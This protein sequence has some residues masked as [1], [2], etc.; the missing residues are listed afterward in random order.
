MD[1]VRYKKTGKNKYKITLSN[2]VELTIYEDVILK[3]ELL[4]KKKIND[5]DLNKIKELNSYY[6][7]YYFAVNSLNSKFKSISDMKKILKDKEYSDTI[8]DDVTNKLIEQGYLNDNSYARSFI[9]NQIITTN[10]G[11]YKIISELNKHNIKSSIVNEEIDVF[12]EDIQ[13]EKMDKVINKSLKSNK[14]RGGVVLKKKII[15]DLINLG[16]SI[17]IIDKVINKYKFN[18]DKD[19]VQKEYEKIYKR[20]SRKYDGD[21]LKYKVKEQLYRRGL[22]YED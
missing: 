13:I 21:E 1:I 19:I 3:Y 8:I 17:D 22:Y 7:A 9:N 5:K 15:N 14:T 18:T 2:N 16:Y 10:R 6:E 11:P 20:L 12:T 4:L